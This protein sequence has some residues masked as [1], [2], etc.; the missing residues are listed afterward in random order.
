MIHLGAVGC[1]GE[2]KH[3]LITS[4]ND[5]FAD[6]AH[7]KELVIIK[8]S[9]CLTTDGD[10]EC[11]D[12]QIHTLAADLKSSLDHSVMCDVCSLTDM[13]LDEI[14]ALGNIVLVYTSI[15]RDTGDGIFK[16]GYGKGAD[17]Y[18]NDNYS[19]TEDYKTMRNDQ[20]SMLLNSDY[21]SHDKLFLLSWTLTLNTEDATYCNN[22]ILDLASTAS[23]RLF[24]EMW[25]LVD[26]GQLTKSLFPNILY[27][28]AFDS[29][30]TRT[31]I[32][33]NTEY[34]NLED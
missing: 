1:H 17:Y 31:A 3:S 29:F 24:E 9:H 32:Y 18:L 11:T 14:L 27:V 15:D 12:D 19:N 6:G 34:G 26:N 20:N 8:V 5:F 23:P 4:L 30:A 13:T 33:L 21:H 2:D 28:D 7:Q 22:T 25:K 16:W 10:N